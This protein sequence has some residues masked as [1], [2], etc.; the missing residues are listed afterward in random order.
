VSGRAGRG[1]PVFDHPNLRVLLT[2]P[3]HLLAMKVRAARS[4]RDAEDI[5][6]LMRQLDISETTQVLTIVER[7]FPDEPLSDR[8]LMLVEDL[9]AR[10]EP[11]RD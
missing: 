5:R 7:F 10:Q 2:P 3:E 4:A 8:S 11:G 1:T 9:V 6:L